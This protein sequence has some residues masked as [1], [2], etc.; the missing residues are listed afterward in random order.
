MPPAYINNME[1]FAVDLFKNILD[2]AGLVVSRTLVSVPAF[3]GLKLAGAESKIFNPTD[4]IIVDSAKTALYASSV[5]TIA[6]NI[7]H[8]AMKRM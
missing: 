3:F 6:D 5:I 2:D 1:S 4:H 7:A 8:V